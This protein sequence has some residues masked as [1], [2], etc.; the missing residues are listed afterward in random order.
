MVTGARDDRC[1][2]VIGW[3][4]MSAIPPVADPP[5]IRFLNDRW[6]ML[7]AIG[8]GAMGDV[9]RGRHRVLG[10]EVAIKLMKLAAARDENL[11]ARFVREARIAAQLRHRHIARVEDFG[12]TAD[13]LSKIGCR[14][15]GGSIRTSR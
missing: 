12:T 10:H 13:G 11:V 4:V 7:E 14:R 9:W 2:T 6:E 5:T 1:L 3:A 8:T 15:M